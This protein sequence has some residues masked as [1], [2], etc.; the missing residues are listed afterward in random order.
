MKIAFINNFIIDSPS[1]GIKIQAETW[2]NGLEK[3]GHEVTLIN[4]WETDNWSIYDIILIFKYGNALFEY[5]KTLFPINPNI[6]L[7]PIIDSNYSPKTFYWASKY[8]KIDSL[9]LRSNYN[10]IYKIKDKIKLYFVRSNYEK[11]FISEGLKIPEERIFIIPLSSRFIDFPTNNIKENFCFH[12]SIIEKG[13]KNV[14]RLIEAAIKYQF[15]LKLAGFTH[16]PQKIHDMIS[17]YSNI[18]YIGYLSDEELRQYYK[19]AK[20]FALPSIYEGVGMAALEAASYGSDIVITKIG[21]PKEY[22]NNMAYQVNPYDVDDIGRNILKAFDHSHQPAL[23]KYIFENYN[24]DKCMK[25]LENALE[26]V[27]NT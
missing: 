14:K 1:N 4:P 3:I 21:G 23:Q 8:L 5:V 24:L 27:L 26:K 12:V 11:K 15:N 18:E 19:R 9:R 17:P 6:V 20:V 16:N 22:Y 10:D 2:K 13:H 7:A 25:K